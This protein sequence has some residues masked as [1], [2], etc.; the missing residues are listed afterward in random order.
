MT[1]QQKVYD[2]LTRYH[3][4][5]RSV[6]ITP[7]GVM[8]YVPANCIDEQ[9]DG[10]YDDIKESLNDESDVVIVHTKGTATVNEFIVKNKS[11]L[12]KNGWI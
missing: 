4:M 10:M 3:I 12:K 6:A 5:D 8:V 1:K 7:K 2:V 9:Y 11:I